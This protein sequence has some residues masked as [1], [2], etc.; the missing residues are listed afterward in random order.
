MAVRDPD[1]PSCASANLWVS[2]I[3]LARCWVPTGWWRKCQVVR[4][5]RGKLLVCVTCL[6]IGLGIRRLGQRS[7]TLGSSVCICWLNR[8]GWASSFVL[9]SCY[10]LLFFT[11][12]VIHVLFSVILY[13][14]TW[15]GIMLRVRD[16]P[17]M[18]LE[19]LAFSGSLLCYSVTSGGCALCITY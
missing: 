16:L 10:F 2:G 1:E 4:T 14:P 19:V 5:F 18:A 8:K 9:T 15:P 17:V 12:Y 7:T 13:F 6:E 11:F 3:W